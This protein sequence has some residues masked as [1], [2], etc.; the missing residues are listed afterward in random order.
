MTIT[1]ELLKKWNA[2]PGRY[3]AGDGDRA[4]R[5]L[6]A[7]IAERARSRELHAALREHGVERWNFEEEGR[8]KLCEY[9]WQDGA[10]EKHAPSCL[11]APPEEVS[12]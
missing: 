10:L 8:C 3:F 4:V 6:D 12:P 9:V 1:D 2:D 7:L 5:L 11:A